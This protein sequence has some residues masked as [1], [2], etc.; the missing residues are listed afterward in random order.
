MGEH[1]GC[2]PRRAG[3]TPAGG[4]R[5]PGL[6]SARA[7]EQVAERRLDDRVAA[8]RE[9][10]GLDAAAPRARPHFSHRHPARAQR[11]AQ[12]AC[13]GASLVSQVALG[14]AV[15]EG[16]ALR[17][18]DAG[19]GECMADQHHLPAALRQPPHRLVGVGHGRRQPGGQQPQRSPREGSHRR[20]FR[21]SRRGWCGIHARRCAIPPP[22]AQA[23]PRGCVRWLR[24]AVRRR[25][26]P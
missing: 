10:R 23:W 9:L 4:A 7:P 25:V 2:C 12:R 1:H 16:H 26:R 13:M 17:V 8:Q 18:T 20:A 3:A 14:R 21:V 24:S 19:C 11:V 6:P 5:P 22:A 15:R